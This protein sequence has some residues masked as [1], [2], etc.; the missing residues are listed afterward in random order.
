MKIYLDICLRTLSIPSSQRSSES[1]GLISN[2]F[3]S[4]VVYL[5]AN[6]QCACQGTQDDKLA[7]N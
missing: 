2:R 3:E 7:G 1:V 4:A 5:S 6:K